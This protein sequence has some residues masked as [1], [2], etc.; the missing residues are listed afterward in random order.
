MEVKTATRPRWWRADLDRSDAA[1]AM[2]ELR[3]A[4]RRHVRRRRGL[5][6]ECGI[7]PCTS[8]CA[9]C[10]ERAGREASCWLRSYA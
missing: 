5:C 7:V 4:A 2:A 3:T 6:G 1:A 10:R 8:V 9:S